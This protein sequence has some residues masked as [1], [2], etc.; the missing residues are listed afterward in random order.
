MKI[1]IRYW[2]IYRRSEAERQREKDHVTRFGPHWVVERVKRPIGARDYSTDGSP[3]GLRTGYVGIWKGCT[4]SAGKA[5]PNRWAAQGRGPLPCGLGGIQIMMILRRWAID[6]TNALRLSNDPFAEQRLRDLINHIAE[7]TAEQSSPYKQE[8]ASVEF[9]R[10]DKLSWALDPGR[11]NSESNELQG[12]CDTYVAAANGMGL[13]NITR[14]IAERRAK[15]GKEPRERKKAGR[16][17]IGPVA[18]TSAERM[19]K[20]RRNKALK[21]PQPTGVTTVGTDQPMPRLSSAPTD[22]F[23]QAQ[24]GDTT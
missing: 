20:H 2:D 9:D 8:I 12:T 24:G 1:R 6:A 4:A 17:P 21:R 11:D 18:Q 16:K 22:P 23:P 19:R 5:A 7:Q 10:T 14:T 13:E 3:Y 15:H